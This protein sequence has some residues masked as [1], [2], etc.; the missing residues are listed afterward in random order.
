MDENHEHY[1]LSEASLI[2]RRVLDKL[3][4]S[5][6]TIIGI[7]IV[8]AVV[9]FVVVDKMNQTPSPGM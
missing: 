9:I 3:I 8:I 2:R 6:V 5:A 1:G 7:I 4:V